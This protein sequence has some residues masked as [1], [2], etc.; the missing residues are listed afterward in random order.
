MRKRVV[1]GSSLSLGG[2]PFMS[3][4][5][6]KEIIIESLLIYNLSFYNYCVIMLGVLIN[7]IFIELVFL[8]IAMTGLNR[9]RAIFRKED[10]DYSVK[11]KNNYLI[12][13]CGERG[14]GY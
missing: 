6:S 4:F 3:A 7:N 14:S 2:L 12:Y 13:S 5:Y 11:L 8:I 1:I 10:L 9:Q